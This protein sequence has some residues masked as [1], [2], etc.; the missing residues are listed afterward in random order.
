MARLL[1]NLVA[2]DPRTNVH[3][4]QG[5]LEMVILGATVGAEGVTAAVYEEVYA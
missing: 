3:G 5:E 2:L 4:R 1:P